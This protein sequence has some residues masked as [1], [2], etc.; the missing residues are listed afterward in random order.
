MAIR[1]SDKHLVYSIASV[2][3]MVYCPAFNVAMFIWSL[4]VAVPF[5][6]SRSATST[7]HYVLV[8]LFGQC[9]LW[10]SAHCHI[11]RSRISLFFII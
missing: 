4:P 2:F 3:D 5:L 6:I 8:T 11:A 9:G 7:T 1:L 10:Y